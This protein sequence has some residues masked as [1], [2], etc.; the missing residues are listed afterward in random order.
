MNWCKISII[1]IFLGLLFI[2]NLTAT[3]NPVYKE[4]SQRGYQ[5]EGNY[6]VFPDST[7]CL[8]EEFNSG[9]CGKKWMT[10]D[11]CIPEGRYVWDSDRCCEG[12]VAYLPKGMA[13]QA[14]CVKKSE[15]LAKRTFIDSYGGI[16]LLLL[17]LVAILFLRTS[18]N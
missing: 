17:A 9:E 7:K 15:A 12:L 8:L 10:D 3:I 6:C 1:W 2:P 18:I 13:G 11:Y 16:A 5:I 14:S 4:C